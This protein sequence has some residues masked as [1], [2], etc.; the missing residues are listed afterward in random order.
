MS[1]E[2]NFVRATISTEITFVDEAAAK[3]YDCG[4]CLDKIKNAIA[5]CDDQLSFDLL[6]HL[7]SKCFVQNE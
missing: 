1:E 5:V 3:V 6:S 7:I 2:K 4:I